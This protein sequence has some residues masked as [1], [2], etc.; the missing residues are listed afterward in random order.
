MT[1]IHPTAI[2][3][4]NVKIGEGTKVWHFAHIRENAK[5]GKGCVIS[6]DV[7][8]GQGVVIGDRCK[9]E[10]GVNIP[11]GVE[12]GDEVII[13][14]NATF[15]NDKYPRAI[16][17]HWKTEK[18]FIRKG[19][20]IGAGA[21]IVCG[22]EIGEYAMVGAG[23]VITKSILPYALAFNTN[24]YAELA[25]WVCKCG[26]RVSVAGQLCKECKSE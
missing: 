23:S 1:F 7:Y 12:I 17:P 24:S 26:K 18:T 9:I 16:S 21:V 25:G 11:N 14:P 3:D 22:I 6:K 10:N 13:C 19:A 8:I 4:G 20:S 5:I 15:T 2:I